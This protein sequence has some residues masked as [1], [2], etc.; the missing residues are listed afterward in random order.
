MSDSGKRW[1]LGTMSRS[2]EQKKG[3]DKEMATEVRDDTNL[4]DRED[5]GELDIPEEDTPKKRKRKSSAEDFHKV[6]RA[7]LVSAHGFTS[8]DVWIEKSRRTKKPTLK[9]FF[10]DDEITLNRW[11]DVLAVSDKIRQ[12]L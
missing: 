12:G 3:K 9:V 11:S 6:A 4:D 10:E 2:R 5:R 1:G 8:E 7:F